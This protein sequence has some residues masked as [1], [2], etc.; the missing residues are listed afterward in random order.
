MEIR[1][2]KEHPKNQEGI[3]RRKQANKKEAGSGNSSTDSF[4][5]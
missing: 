4:N 1:N 5:S 2:Y 3:A